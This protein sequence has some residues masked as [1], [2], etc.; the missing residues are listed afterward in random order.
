[1][2]VLEILSQSIKP[3]SR[4]LYFTKLMMLNDG[5]EIHDLHFLENVNEVMKKIKHFAVSTQRSYLI[6]IVSLLREIVKTNASYLPLFNQ[7]YSM[8]M[9]YNHDLL[10]NNVKSNKEEKNWVEQDEIKAKWQE[11][12]GVLNDVKGC[13]LIP[14]PL[15]NKLRDFVIL[16]LYT[17]IPPRRNMDYVQMVCNPTN[18]PEYNNLLVGKGKAPWHFL[19]N[20]YKTAGTY[21]QQK[22][23]IPEN[24][25]TILK[26]W[27]KFLPNKE[28][29]LLCDFNGSKLK[30]NQITLLL[31]KIFGKKVGCSML[32]KS[33]LTDKYGKTTKALANDATDMG[34]SVQTISNQYV[35]E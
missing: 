5:K 20:N 31:N 8:M 10:H 19:F 28:G 7:Y 1:M 17:L 4:K 14:P 24:L 22:I 18:N 27:M 9:E 6:S 2:N 16:S 35:K 21:A 11:L 30:D 23:A 15:F 32:R 26:V 29:F 12:S 34:T 13:K 3:S 25:K 33:Y